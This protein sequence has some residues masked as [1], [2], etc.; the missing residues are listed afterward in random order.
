[1][2]ARSFPAALAFLAAVALL[3]CSDPAAE[4]DEHLAAGR[5]ALAERQPGEAIHAFKSAL[6]IDPNSIDAHFG[7]A[8]AYLAGRQARQALWEFD[9]TVRLDPDHHASRIQLARLLRFGTSEDREAAVAHAQHVIDAQSLGED[10]PKRWVAWVAK[11]RALEPLGREDEARAAYEKAA[12]LAPDEGTPAFVLGRLLQRQGDRAGAEAQYRRLIEREPG[13][14]STLV[15]AGFLG[16]ERSR[17]DEAEALYRE[18]V[19]QAAPHEQ[20]QGIQALAGFLY[21][22]GRLDEAVQVLEEGLAEREDDPDLV[23]ALAGLY[24]ASGDLDQA[25]ATLA[26]AVERAAENDV[27]PALRLADFRY[28]RGDVEGA[29]AAVEAALA[30]SP[31]HSEARLRKAEL[32]IQTGRTSGDAARVAQGRAIV[33]AALAEDEG[34]PE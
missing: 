6:Q 16:R 19:A 17:D 32:L 1:M 7:L 23:A 29:L 22:R 24:H 12:E 33:D 5:A 10:D 28:A 13:F 14:D 26:G 31:T 18:A 3:A 8:Q 20:V 30:S 2:R 9:E 15:L 27:Q 11:G 4:L 25:E 21:A 34:S